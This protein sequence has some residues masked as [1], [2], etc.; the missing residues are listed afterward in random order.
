MHFIKVV[1]QTAHDFLFLAFRS[2][3]EISAID[4]WLSKGLAGVKGK[5]NLKALI[6]RVK[7]V[8]KWSPSSKVLIL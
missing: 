1:S 7:M 4:V 6:Q 5:E 8:E 3:G 2:Q